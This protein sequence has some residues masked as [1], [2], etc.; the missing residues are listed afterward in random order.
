MIELKSFKFK[1][2]INEYT[3]EEYEKVTNIIAKEQDNYIQKWIDI[4]SVFCD[5]DKIITALTEED[6]Y[7]YMDELNK[8]VLPNK[9]L[10]NKIQIGEREW[11]AYEGEEFK[12]K[13]KDLSYIEK[14]IKE[15]HNFFSKILAILFK[16]PLLEDNYSEEVISERSEI[17][18]KLIAGDYLNYITI[19]TEKITK[20]IVIM[21]D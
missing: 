21:N 4:F 18:K 5:N 9:I 16:D 19:V 8:E 3:I 7:A 14:Y 10:K 20:K 1:T 15:P 13:L 11:I 6:L 12:L 17:F 2:N